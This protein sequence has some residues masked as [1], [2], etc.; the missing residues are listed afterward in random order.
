MD[1][2]K[3][4]KKVVNHIEENLLS[5]LDPLSLSQMTYISEFYFYRFFYTTS[6]LAIII[7]A[8]TL[9]I[10]LRKYTRKSIEEFIYPNPYIAGNPIRS[11]EIFFGR[12]DVFEF[13]RNKLSAKKQS[14]DSKSTRN[15]FLG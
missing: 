15:S 2:L 14:V 11:K 1:H 13:I 6:F 3:S 12:K 10:S 7:V 5:P 4:I 8:L 9:K